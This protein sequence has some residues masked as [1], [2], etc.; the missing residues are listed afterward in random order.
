M[1]SRGVEGSEFPPRRNL[2]PECGRQQWPDSLAE[3]QQG[4]EA[5]L[6]GE[7]QAQAAAQQTFVQRTRHGLLHQ[8]AA[9][10]QQAVIVDTGRAGGFTGTAGQAAV[11][12]QPGRCGGGVPL[13]YLL[14]LVDAPAWPVKLVT[15]QL[16]GGAGRIAEAAVHAVAQDFIGFHAGSGL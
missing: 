4:R 3:A 11:E 16:V 6:P 10:I 15:G 5:C 13:E 2:P 14:D 1:L 9:G 7:H 8:F 12:V